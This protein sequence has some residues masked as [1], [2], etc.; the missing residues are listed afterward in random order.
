MQGQGSS[1]GVEYH[2]TFI[3]K[4]PKVSVRAGFRASEFYSF[5]QSIDTDWNLWSEDS[6]RET[7]R[8]QIHSSESTYFEPDWGMLTDENVKTA[9]RDWAMRTLEDGIERRMIEAIAPVPGRRAQEARRHRGRHPRHHQDQDLE[10]QPA[11]TPSRTRS[12]GTSGRTG[13]CRT[14]PR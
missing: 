12:S 9:I 11:A 2:L 1:V 8:E 7:V 5:Y 10:L 6:Y 4:L 14:S 3:A 13:R